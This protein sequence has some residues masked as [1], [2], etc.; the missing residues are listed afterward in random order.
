MLIADRHRHTAVI[1]KHMRSGVKVVAMQPNTLVV[2]KMTEDELASNWK[3]MPD[4][5]VELAICRYLE[6]PGGVSP[7]ARSAL[8]DMLS[9]LR[10]AL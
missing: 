7:A 3:T 1:V 6:H 10:S 2:T 5:P 8:E 4:Y 9:K